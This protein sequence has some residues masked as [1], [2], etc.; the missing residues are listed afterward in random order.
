MKIKILTL[1]LC[2]LLAVTSLFAAAPPVITLASTDT[3]VTQ[4]T[5]SGL[6]F[7][8]SGT[9][10]IVVLGATTLSLISFSDTQI[11]AAIPANEPSGS[12]LMSVTETSGGS[13][14]TTFGVTISAVAA[15]PTLPANAMVGS[16]GNISPTPNGRGVCFPMMGA[17]TSFGSWGDC[18]AFAGS[19]GTAPFTVSTY[20]TITLTISPPAPVSAVTI[21]AFGL[22]IGANC[23]IP[24]GQTSCTQTFAPFSMTQGDPIGVA[25]H[26]NSAT[27]FRI[28]N[29]TWAIY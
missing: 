13:K 5:I 14:T 28:T 19:F 3:A 23:T 18:A 4:L 27:P 15:P 29:A 6:G 24:A 11:I 9:T 26:L 20:T 7:S 21:T 2:S 1:L 8:P 25:I 22:S 12:Y 17:T 10:P 16:A